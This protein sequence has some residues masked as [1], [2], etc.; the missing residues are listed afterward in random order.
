MS[1]SHRHEKTDAKATPLVLFGVGL[2]VFIVIVF[3]ALVGMF[4]MMES[5]SERLEKK[6]H[7][8]TEAAGLPEE[9][10]LQINAAQEVQ[11]LKKEKEDILNSYG[12]I[13]PQAGVVR[14][15]IDRAMDL[16][17]KRDELKSR[18]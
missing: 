16:L 14:I 3:V 8:L 4:R 1:G 5:A 9:P 15:P 10:R 2:A 13:T 6:P 7:P 12:W 11:I 17:I 18:E